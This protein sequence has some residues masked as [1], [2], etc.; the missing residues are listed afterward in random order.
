MMVIIIFF[1][2][3]EVTTDLVSVDGVESVINT[4]HE[5]FFKKNW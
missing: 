3:E 1:E 4:N 2:L 5:K